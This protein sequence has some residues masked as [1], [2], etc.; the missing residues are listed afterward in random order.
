VSDWPSE[1][2]EK[3]AEVLLAPSARFAS[4]KHLVARA[5][6]DAIRDDIVL[7]SEMNRITESQFGRQTRRRYVT[8]R[9]PIDE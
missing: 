2:V 9:E 5:V 1:L 4:N 8:E 3:V 7:K 6:L